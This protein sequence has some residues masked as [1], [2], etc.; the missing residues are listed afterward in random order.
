MTRMQLVALIENIPLNSKKVI[1][2]RKESVRT[3]DNFP[4]S[5]AGASHSSALGEIQYQRP[6]VL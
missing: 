3:G 2:V 6:L 1:L 4:P 5:R